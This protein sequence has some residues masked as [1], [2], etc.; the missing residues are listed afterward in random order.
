MS[1]FKTLFIDLNY[2]GDAYTNPSN[3]NKIIDVGFRT[4]NNKFYVLFGV[5]NKQFVNLSRVL[6]IYHFQYLRRDSRCKL[7]I[8]FIAI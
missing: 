1:K 4:K 8:V 2:K 5:L 3:Y 7:G 6:S